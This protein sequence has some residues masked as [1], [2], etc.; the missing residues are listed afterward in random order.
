MP[1]SANEKLYN[2]TVRHGIDLARFENYHI[3]QVQAWLQDDL[4]PRVKAQLE[5]FNKAGFDYRTKAQQSILDRINDVVGGSMG[6]MSKG[7]YGEMKTLAKEEGKAITEAVKRLTP[8][9][10]GFELPNLRTL[11]SIVMDRPFEGRILKEYFDELAPNA[12]TLIQNTIKDGMFRGLSIPDM[13]TQ[14]EGSD[15]FTGTISQIRNEAAK[16]VRT[17]VQHVSSH[18][19]Q[20]TYQEN[21]DIIKGYQV[22][23][24]LDTRICEICVPKDG[25]VITDIEDFS[26]MPPFHFNC[27]CSTVPVLKSWNEL[28]IDLNEAPEGTRASMSGQV[29]DKLTATEWLKKQPISVQQ[30]VLGKTKGNL[31]NQGQITAKS[32]TKNNQVLNLRQV[33]KRNRLSLDE[34][35]EYAPKQVLTVLKGTA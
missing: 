17:A 5:R 19:R 29:S 18:A 13:V 20:A 10:I 27:R 23:G 3:G 7:L 8:V 22:V 2:Y 33:I 25:E 30:D 26:L 31:F 28:G 4:M 9:D 1:D 32:L 21:E 24:T 6:T 34:I 35:E 16:Y 14:L 15:I 12:Q 11:S